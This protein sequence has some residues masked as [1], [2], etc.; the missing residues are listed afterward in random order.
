[1]ENLKYEQA[2]EKLQQITE[3]LESGELTLEE[4]VCAYEEGMK[5]VA[6][7]RKQLDEAES[8]VTVLSSGTES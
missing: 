6:F 2:I 4:S 5:L 1:M 8:K 3:K 7:C